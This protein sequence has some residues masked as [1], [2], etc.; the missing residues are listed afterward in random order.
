[1]ID[2]N[3][4]WN[5]FLKG[6]LNKEH[7]SSEETSCSPNHIELCTHLPLNL[8]HLSMQYSQLGPTGGLYRKV[9]LYT[10]Q[11]AGSHWWPL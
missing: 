11:P 2:D 7:L 3:L 9:P 1:M 5:L 6:T 10:G 8:G 4:Q